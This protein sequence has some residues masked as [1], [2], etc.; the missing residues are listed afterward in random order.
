MTFDIETAIDTIINNFDH[1]K[2]TG[3]SGKPPRKYPSDV[4]LYTFSER[5]T[6]GCLKFNQ[7][8]L[9]NTLRRKHLSRTQRAENSNKILIF[10]VL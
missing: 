1:T 9:V 5:Q 10:M 6:D 8:K 2:V 4:D 7:I 3:C